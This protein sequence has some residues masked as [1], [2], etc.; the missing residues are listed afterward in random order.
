MATYRYL[1]ADLLTNTI[2]GELPL[3]GVSFGAGG[4]GYATPGNGANGIIIVRYAL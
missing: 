4:G 2:I 3:T 1:F